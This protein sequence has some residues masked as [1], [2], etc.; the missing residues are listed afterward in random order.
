VAQES[1]SWQFDAAIAYFSRL[2]IGH[3]VVENI[4]QIIQEVDENADR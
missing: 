4:R 3:S 1:P 2:G